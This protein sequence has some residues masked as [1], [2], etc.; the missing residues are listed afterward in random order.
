[1]RDFLLGVAAICAGFSLGSGPDLR[2]AA[3]DLDTSLAG[4]GM[5]QIGFGRS[6]DQ[7]NAVA[8]QADGKVLMAGTIAGQLVLTRFDTNNV[9]DETFGSSGVVYTSLSRYPQISAMRIQLDG[10]IVVAGAIYV[11]SNSENDFFLARF[12]PDGTPDTSFGDDGLASRDYSGNS[13]EC[14]ALIIQS[15]GK[16]VVGGISRTSYPTYG[17]F[18][19]LARFD[20][21]GFLDLSFNGN[22]WIVPT[23][24]SG[25]Y[26]LAQQ[27]DGKILVGGYMG[28]NQIF[29]F[30][31]NGSPDTTFGV[32]GKVRIPSLNSVLALTIQPGDPFFLNPDMIVAASKGTVNAQGGIYVARIALGGGL[33]TGFNGT[34]VASLAIGSDVNISGLSVLFA[35]RFVRRIV[36]SGDFSNAGNQDFWLARFNVNGTADTTFGNG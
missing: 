28:T 21:N 6:D 7:A 18:M 30:N 10:K 16:L 15:D 3:G 1:M 31:P 23:N 4:S 11:N 29:R 26:C 35:S 5:L 25:A 34:G 33:D 9:L 36:L 19:A 32:G 20:T 22:G 27:S 12:N 8:L 24:N 13:E 14:T 17:A 2:A